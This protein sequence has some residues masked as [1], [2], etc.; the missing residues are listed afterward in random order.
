MFL[1][2]HAPSW[3]IGCEGL[4]DD[5]RVHTTASI[6]LHGAWMNIN[7]RHHCSLSFRQY[8]ET[9]KAKYEGSSGDV[10]R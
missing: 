10:L 4:A 1:L 9:I 6:A 8:R 2:C 7:H 5:I 3:L